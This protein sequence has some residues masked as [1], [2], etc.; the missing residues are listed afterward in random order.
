LEEEMHVVYSAGDSQARGVGVRARRP[1]RLAE[2]MSRLGIRARG[3]AAYE[4]LLHEADA[5]PETFWREV[6][7]YFGIRFAVPCTRILDTSFGMPWTVWCVGGE[8]NLVHHCLDRHRDTPVWTK[9]ALVWQSEDGRSGTLSYRELDGAVCRLA[10]A[11]CALGVG[12][13]E[14][15]GLRL[16]GIHETVIAT[17]AVLKIGAVLLPLERTLGAD[18]LARRLGDAQAAAL[19]TADRDGSGTETEALRTAIA[20][21]PDLRHHIIVCERGTAIARRR[22]RLQRWHRLIRRGAAE[23][24]TVT[25][26]ADAPALIAY[27]EEGSGPAVATVQT[28]GGFLAKTLADFGLCL[29]WRQQD[30][31]AWIADPGTLAGPLQI[32]ATTL[33]GATLILAGD[34]KSAAWRFA[35]ACEASVLALDCDRID[36]RV[37]AGDPAVAAA[38][39]PALRE[40]VAVGTGWRA[41]QHSWIAARLCR[42]SVP[43]LHYETCVALGGGVLTGTLLHGAGCVPVPGCRLDLVAVRGDARADAATGALVLRRP[44]IALT[45]GLW[46]DPAGYLERYWSRGPEVCDLGLTAQR[47]TDGSWSLL[48]RVP[49]NPGRAPAAGAASPVTLHGHAV[50]PTTLDIARPA[51]HPEQAS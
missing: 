8:T 44:Y 13:G 29:D 21:L 48:E 28:H 24:P 42:D 46:S 37:A 2:F 25:R 10:I 3:A 22:P 27:T 43:L 34:E 40:V 15:V 35:G 20:E 49:P 11:L 30:R 7:D 47:R 5:K 4:R 17:L 33:L 38:V 32:V 12:P 6:F 9:P 45:R 19:V 31:V 16:P 14:V 39:S 41:D 50:N 23:F 1:S 26:A 36:P 18:E 51:R